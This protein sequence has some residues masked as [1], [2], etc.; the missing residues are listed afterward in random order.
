M[1]FWSLALIVTAIAC[2]ALYYAGARARVNAATVDVDSPEIAHLRGQLREIEADAEAGRIGE[3]DVVAARAE[4]ARELIRVKAAARPVGT[5]PLPRIAVLG[6]V[7][8][9]ALVALGVYAALGRPDM[10]A[11]PIAVRDDLPAP[12][13]QLTL[14]AAVARIEAELTTNPG[15]MRGWRVLAPAYMQLGRF[16]EAAEALRKVIAAEGAD[17]DLETDLGEA[18][19][20]A[21]GGDISGEA[22]ALFESAAARDPAH[23]RSRYYIASAAMQA[24]DLEAAKQL[25]G[26]LIALAKGDEPW[27]AN[28]RAGLAAAEGDVGQMDDEAILGMVDQLAERLATEGGTVEEW[29]R[30]VRSRLVLGQGEEAQKA[31]QAARAAIP[32]AAERQPLDVLAADNGLMVGQ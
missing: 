24:G 23:A 12:T 2:A 21:G 30:L 32:D 15:D 28:A 25:W 10:P 29:T 7:A 27:L 3:G 17:A 5:A 19:M 13:E 4:V 9:T 11:Q 6:S 20:M 18:V 8:A 22:L 1:I 26:G 16:A 14:D 31:Y